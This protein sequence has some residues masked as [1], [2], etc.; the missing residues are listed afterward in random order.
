MDRSLTESLESADTTVYS[1]LCKEK[2]QQRDGLSMIAS[3]NSASL[4]VLQAL[5]SCAHNRYCDGY[6]GD[7]FV[8]K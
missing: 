3:E 6:P 1:L 7:R 2:E 8:S 4:A 5:G